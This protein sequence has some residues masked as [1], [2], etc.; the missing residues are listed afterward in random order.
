MKCTNLSHY[1]KCSGNDVY[2]DFS[3][4][5]IHQGLAEFIMCMNS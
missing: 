4:V 1:C 2:Y 3:D 5:I